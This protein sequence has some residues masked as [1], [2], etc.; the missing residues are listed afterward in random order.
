LYFPGSTIGNFRPAAAVQLLT[1]MADEVG[2]SGAVLVGVDLVK[3]RKILEDAYN[4]AQGITAE[5]NLN[6]LRRMNR[7][8]G[9]DFDADAFEHRAVWVEARGTIEMRL[10]SKVAQTVRVGTRQFHFEAG[11]WIHTEDSHKYTL[12]GF[13]SL[14]A[15][16]GLRV[17]HVWT[18]RDRLFSVQYLERQ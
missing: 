8:F 18:D 14:A 11:E 10:Y 13:E 1:Q 4:D 2:P 9:S 7:E 15:R 16:A 3:D 17:E 6:L 12:E 5:F